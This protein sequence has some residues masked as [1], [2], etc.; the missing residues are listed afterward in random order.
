M[1]EITR[2]RAGINPQPNPTNPL[3]VLQSLLLGQRPKDPGMAAMADI[4]LGSQSSVNRGMSAGMGSGQGADLK[5]AAKK[6]GEL[7]QSPEGLLGGLLDIAKDM[8]RQT[9]QAATLPAAGGESPEGPEE[10]LPENQQAVMDEVERNRK[11]NAKEAVMRLGPEGAM[12]AAKNLDEQNASRQ[13]PPGLQPQANNL[14][15]RTPQN[16]L[17]ALFQQAG[18]DSETGQIK[19]GGL[20]NLVPNPVT[21]KEALDLSTGKAE[22][23]FFEKETFKSGLDLKN[24]MLFEDYKHELEGTNISDEQ[25][26]VIAFQNSFE[27]VIKSFMGTSLRGPARGKIP[28]F[29]ANAQQAEAL[30]SA[31]AAQAAMFFTDQSGRSFSDKDFERIA[32]PLRFKRDLPAGQFIGRLNASLALLR[33]KAKTEGINLPNVSG[34]QAIE[35]IRSGRPMFGIESPVQSGGGQTQGKVG[36]KIIRG[37]K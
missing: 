27:E 21:Q 36:V 31:F 12:Q 2:R 16:L 7:S 26:G 15:V 22:P 13:V 19:T 29:T 37:I 3:S 32:E 20:F 25:K 5:K 33:A 24:K 14:N 30:S 4:V 1:A 6:T 18:I 28:A 11:K 8:S 23:S 34:K 9:A 17:E 10:T 35:N